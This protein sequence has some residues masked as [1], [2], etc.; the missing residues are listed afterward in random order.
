MSQLIAKR[1]QFS[2]INQPTHDQGPA[3]LGPQLINRTCVTNFDTAW[4]AALVNGPLS[5]QTIA[6]LSAT[7]DECAMPEAQSIPRP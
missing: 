2:E 1:S 7:L 5:K 6:G 4:S 3:F